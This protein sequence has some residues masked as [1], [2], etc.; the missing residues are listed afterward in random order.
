MHTLPYSSASTMLLR[1]SIVAAAILGV[2][3]GLS[4]SRGECADSTDQAISML[5]LNFAEPFVTRS[6]AERLALLAM[7]EKYP[8]T[9][10]SGTPPDTI[11]KG[12]EW[13]VTVKVDHWDAPKSL[14]Y[15]ALLAHQLTIVIRK[16]DAAILSME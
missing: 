13:W 14:S 6:F 11:D 16:K 1:K 2:I 12:E 9:S 10:L 8:G 7:S 15:G 3:L 4:A 5:L